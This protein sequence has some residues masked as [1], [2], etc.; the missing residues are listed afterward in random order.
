MKFLSL[1]PEVL[2]I[3]LGIVLLFTLFYLNNRS[4]G[5]ADAPTTLAVIQQT[6]GKVPGATQ[7]SAVPK[8]TPGATSSDPTAAVPQGKDIED[9]QERLKNLRLLAMEKSPD[10]TDLS[11]NDRRKIRVLINEIPSL[12]A[13]L[14]TALANFD[15]SGLTLEALKTKRAE[16]DKAI[17]LLRNARLTAPRASPIEVQQTL[18]ALK[19][20]TTLATQKRPENTNLAPAPKERI[21]KLRDDVPDLE[22]RLLAALAQSD[23]SP[24]TSARLR[25]IRANIMSAH[26]ELSSATVIGSGAGTQV[27]QTIRIPAPTADETYAA[28]VAAEPQPTVVAGPVGVISVSQL[29]DLVKRI[30]EEALRL[31]N[32]RST[33]A[34]ITARIQQ[35]T[36]LKANIGEFVTKVERGQMKLEDVPISPDAATKFLAGLKSNSEPIPPLI[37]PLGSMPKV[38]KAPTG[39]AQ[40]AGIPAGEQAVNKLLNAAKDLR[41]S[42]E[43]RLEYDPQLKMREKMLERIENIIKNLTKLSVSETP[44]PPKIHEDYLKQI[45]A[46]QSAFAANPP[47]HKGGDVGAMSRL[48]TGY[49]RTP[50]G[51]PNPS[52][53]AV[54]T[55]QG[56]GFGPQANTFPHGEI[57]PDIAIRPGFVMNDEQIARRASAASFIPAAGGADYKARALEICRQVKAAQLGDA[58]SFGCIENPSEVGP[59]YDW[60]GNYTMVCNRLG[61]SWGR[62][63]PE[64]FGCPAYDPTA[65]FSSGF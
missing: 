53:D 17:E 1:K 48:P 42:M 15:T 41:W 33:S 28:R 39:V 7:S 2:L 3:I 20:F 50:Q 11:A 56:A 22:Q 54:S 5:F 24:Y 38:V 16:V 46:M 44:I 8:D 51:A 30:D 65:K 62:A 4:E 47:A 55:A 37:V 57:S 12:E 6:Q 13:K 32:L 34:T 35:L 9:M 63:Y 26:N 14:K 58:K 52:D 10:E 64:Q 40:Y 29:K 18:D 60:K 31:T 23:A 49:A 21:M 59:S 36:L 27:E 45:Q 25:V 19:T 43:V 61:D